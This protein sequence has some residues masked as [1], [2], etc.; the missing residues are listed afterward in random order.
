MRSKKQHEYLIMDYD[1]DQSANVVSK[2][3]FY[4]T[5]RKYKTDNFGW[6]LSLT[7]CKFKITHFFE[8]RCIN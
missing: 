7:E 3:K 8:Y 4:N 1:N 6:W 5:L 2:N